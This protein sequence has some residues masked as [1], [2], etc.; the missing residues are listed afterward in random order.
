[1]INEKLNSQLEALERLKGKQYEQLEFAYA[2][3]KQLTKKEREKRE[4]DRKFEEFMKYTQKLNAHDTYLIVNRNSPILSKAA[5][6]AAKKIQ[7]NAM[8]FDLSAKKPYKNFPKK[9]INL[10][11]NQT[12][13]AGISL[14]STEHISVLY[15]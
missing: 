10:L 6:Q 4:I 2:D 11:Q 8:I 13:K 5:Y 7:L 14:S 1:M 12:P 3:S 9:L 15:G